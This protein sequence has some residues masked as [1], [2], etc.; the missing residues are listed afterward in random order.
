[1]RSL[2]KAILAAVVVLSACG[3]S[4]Q[5]PP[6]NTGTSTTTGE[7]EP[8]V[9]IEDAT[10]V[11]YD[12]TPA[13]PKSKVREYDYDV[14]WS[15]TIKG[16][17]APP[18]IKKRRVRVVFPVPKVEPKDARD[19]HVVNRLL[20][21][22]RKQIAAC[23]YKGMKREPTDELSMVGEIDLSNKGE[24]KAAV[25]EKSDDKMK[26]PGVDDCV[27]E[28]VKGLAFPAAG[29]DTKVRFK[30]KLQILDGAT[31]QDFEDTPVTK[32]K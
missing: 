8:K 7:T 18:E 2:S 6:E 1:M 26:G 27:L 9:V 23:F 19:P 14:T 13:S 22:V 20:W 10:E 25:V 12:D 4:Q 32:D 30:L 21:D 16:S 29:S 11:W 28:N 17:D 3:G 15:T 5:K 31:L 24:V